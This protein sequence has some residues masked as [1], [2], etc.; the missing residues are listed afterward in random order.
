MSVQ[1]NTGMVCKVSSS[2]PATD[3]KAGYE[4]LTWVEVGE[5]TDFPEYGGT[6]SKVEHKPLKT[7]VV[8]K[9]KGFIDYGSVNLTF[10][11]DISDA[12]QVI[13]EDFHDGANQFDNLSIGIFYQDGLT[14]YAQ[15][16]VFSFTRNPGSSDSIVGGSA[17]VEINTKPVRVTA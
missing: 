13:L 5:L 2:L 7:G 15:A 10:G 11:L 16:G 9:H 1:T 3:T 14:E 6:T 8:E 12:G 4:A 17:T